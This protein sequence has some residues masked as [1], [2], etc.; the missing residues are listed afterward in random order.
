MFSIWSMAIIVN[1]GSEG[2]RMAQDNASIVRGFVDEVIT[3]GNIEA[4]AHIE[5]LNRERIS[6]SMTGKRGHQ[7]GLF[8]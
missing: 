2:K 4:A 6:C 1:S 8:W 5:E 7:N 3:N